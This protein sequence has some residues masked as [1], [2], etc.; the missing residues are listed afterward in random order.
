MYQSVQ[1]EH[2]QHKVSKL[3]EMADSEAFLKTYQKRNIP[4]PSLN[5][6]LY[7]GEPFHKN[8][9]HANVP[10]IPDTGYMIHYALRSAD[11]PTEALYQYPDGY[12][13]GNNTPLM[14]GVQPFAGGKYG[15]LCQSAP[16]RKSDRPCD[17]PKCTCS[18]YY[19]L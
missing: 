4:P 2:T 11:P 3:Q 16:R 12:R 15:L 5:G 6:G 7:T 9:G 13:P 8:A 1:P 10:I 17:C 18:K 14:P 19:H